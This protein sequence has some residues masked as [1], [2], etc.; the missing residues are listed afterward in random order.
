MAPTPCPCIEL[1]QDLGFTSCSHSPHAVNARCPRWHQPPWPNQRRSSE[2]RWPLEHSDILWVAAAIPLKVGVEVG[3]DPHPEEGFDRS[4]T[5][6]LAR[7]AGTR[8]PFL[9]VREDT[10]SSV[11]GWSN[12]PRSG[13]S[14]EKKNQES[15]IDPGKG[16]T[17]NPHFGPDDLT[18]ENPS[19]YRQMTAARIRG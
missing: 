17:R 10:V 13:L 1:L 9:P 4:S 5:S 19:I 16:R 15:Y 14:P 11:P 7:E 8:F 6:S 2:C 3:K 12:N 18:Y